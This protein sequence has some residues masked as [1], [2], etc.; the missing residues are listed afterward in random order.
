MSKQSIISHIINFIKDDELRIENNNLHINYDYTN[1]KI[2]YIT[3]NGNKIDIKTYKEILIY[4]YLIINDK[5]KIL[6]YTTLTSCILNVKY[7]KATRVTYINQIK[8]YLKNSSCNKFIKEITN[9][10]NR[11]NI[12]INLTIKL[13][14]NNILSI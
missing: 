10:K 11:F 4:L 9:I 5:D 1:S 13:K 12:D 8:L 6:K 3:I 2:L 14:N 7:I